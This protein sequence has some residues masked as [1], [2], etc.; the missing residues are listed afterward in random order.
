MCV[1][2]FSGLC[3]CVCVCV[4]ESIHL[5]SPLSSSTQATIFPSHPGTTASSTNTWTPGGQRSNTYSTLIRSVKQSLKNHSGHQKHTRVSLS[6]FFLLFFFLPNHL[7]NNPAHFPL[8]SSLSL[9]LTSSLT[10]PNSGSRALKWYLYFPSLSTAAFTSLRVTSPS[11]QHTHTNTHTH[12][13][14][15][16]T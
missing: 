7:I 9:C 10:V 4:C 15:D 3:V 16:H 13:Q 8:P 11:L 2:V 12:T 14:C 6:F 5:S 1:C